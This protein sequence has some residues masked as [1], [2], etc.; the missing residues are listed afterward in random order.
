M[1]R[2][3]FIF[4]IVISFPFSTLGTERYKELLKQDLEVYVKCYAN[5]NYRCMSSYIV[6]SVINKMGGIDGFIK[7]MKF[8]PEMF[9]KSGVE[10]NSKLFTTGEPG[11]IVIEKNILVSI[12]PT[13][14]SI[15]LN[16]KNG[17]IN[18]SII[19]ISKNKGETWFY[20]EGTN[21]G[22]SILKEISNDLYNFLNFP[23]NTLYINGKTRVIK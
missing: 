4:L 19:G 20:V 7:T 12:I 18:A 13:R 14:T 11:P 21:E 8:L 17:I 22:R 2:I 3:F 23:D 6:P 5:Q 9:K 16:G 10:F 15:K 1:K